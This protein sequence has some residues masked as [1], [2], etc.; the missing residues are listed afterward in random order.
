V[1]YSRCQNTR[2]LEDKTTIDIHLCE[3]GFVPSY[4]VCK[5]YGE[6]ETRVV[7]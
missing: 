2:C 6:S 1:P 3:N 7:A 5:F 4:E